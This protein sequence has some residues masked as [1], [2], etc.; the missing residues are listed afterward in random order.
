[1]KFLLIAGLIFSKSDGAEQFNPPRSKPIDIPK[2]IKK[3]DK[4]VKRNKKFLKRYKQFK[5]LREKARQEKQDK[6]K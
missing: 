1:M 6:P 3:L 5:Q 2:V 4:V